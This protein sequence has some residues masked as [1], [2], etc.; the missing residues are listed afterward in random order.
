MQQLGALERFVA[1]L[2]TRSELSDE[3]AGAI[4]ALTGREVGTKGHGIIVRPGQMVEET[5][6]VVRG[7]VGSFDQ[8]HDGS[9]QI[10]ELHIPGDMCDLHSVAVPRVGWGIEA[11]APTTTL[12]IPHAQLRDLAEAYPRIAL[13]FWRDTVA[14]ASVLAKSISVLGRR[15][16]K[17]R[18]AHLL[19]GMGLRMEQADLGRRTHFSLPLTQAQLADVLGLTLTRVHSCLTT[20]QHEGKIDKQGSE[21]EVRDLAYLEDCAQFDPRYL[22]LEDTRPS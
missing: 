19:C 4:L 22:L 20:L 7:I 21:I 8:L 13:A 2:R 18:L 12:R 14:D 10:T 6:L 9:R 11:L 5:C 17:A 15:K 16:A 1:R 3:E